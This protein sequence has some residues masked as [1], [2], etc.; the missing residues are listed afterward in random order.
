MTEDDKVINFVRQSA[1]NTPWIDT[2]YLFGSRA[3]QD[4][5]DTSDYDFACVVDL[6]TSV[7]M[8]ANWCFDIKENNPLLYTLDLIRLDQ[9][10]PGLA[11]A[12][13]EEG[14]IIYEK[15]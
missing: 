11:K 14:I 13:K 15:N 7:Q 8:F 9:V 1:K 6:N 10:D 4:N 12:I 3:R 2:I 5:K